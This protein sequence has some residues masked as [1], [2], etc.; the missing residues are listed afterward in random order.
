MRAVISFETR[1][2]RL[3]G[4][5]PETGL[6]ALRT[7]AILF[8]AANRFTGTLPDNRV[9]AGLRDLSVDCNDFEGAIPSSLNPE[10]AFLGHNL[11]GGPIPQRLLGGSEQAQK[12][13]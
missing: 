4:A 11:L 3:E 9:V 5:I 10:V 8:V 2:N 1:A 7:L 6:A 13:V 12:C